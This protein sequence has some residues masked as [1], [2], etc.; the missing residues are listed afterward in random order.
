MTK[1]WTNLSHNQANPI[2]GSSQTLKQM[3]HVYMNTEDRIP[4][5]TQPFQVF[6]LFEPLLS[7]VIQNFTLMTLSIF[8]LKR[9]ISH[10]LCC[11][12]F[13]QN[14]QFHF[15]EIFSN[16][17]KILLLTC[18]CWGEVGALLKGATVP[19]RAYIEQT[20]ERRSTREKVRS[21]P[22]AWLSP[23]PNLGPGL[24]NKREGRVG[25][26]GSSF[27]QYERQGGSCWAE[28][29]CSTWEAPHAGPKQT[30]AYWVCWKYRRISPLQIPDHKSTSSLS[31]R[32]TD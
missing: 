32:K 27:A 2:N 6:F 13:A 26:W 1:I 22:R 19:W 23:K 12:K 21:A 31:L 17:H 4:I 29:V 10:D 7:F 15:F 11:I 5:W 14:Q 3:G 16:I 20:L 25:D 9:P 18:L 30:K 24:L 28:E 8:F